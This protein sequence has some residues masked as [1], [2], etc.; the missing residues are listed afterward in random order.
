MLRDDL[1]EVRVVDD[2]SIRIIRPGIRF[3]RRSEWQEAKYSKKNQEPVSRHFAF[4]SLAE[5]E[6]SNA[7]GV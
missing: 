5:F 1:C 3:I 4:A 2:Q 6:K 7:V